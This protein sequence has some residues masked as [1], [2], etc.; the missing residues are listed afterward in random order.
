V[1]T[2]KKGRAKSQVDETAKEYTQTK[3]LKK[4]KGKA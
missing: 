2:Q 4:K 3:A 1:K